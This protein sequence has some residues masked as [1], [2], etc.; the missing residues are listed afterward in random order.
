MK[1]ITFLLLSLC[2]FATDSFGQAM[3]NSD[4]SVDVPVL[5]TATPGVGAGWY[6]DS[7]STIAGGFGVLNFSNSSNSFIRQDVNFATAGIYKLQFDVVLGTGV[8]M[9]KHMYNTIR[10]VAGSGVINEIFVLGSGSEGTSVPDNTNTEET[11]GKNMQVKFQNI[12]AGSATYF[13]T[14]TI[15]TPSDKSIYFSINKQSGAA[16]G[17]GSLK[18]SNVTITLES[19]L[20]VD[21]VEDL[22][23]SFAPNPANSH[24]NVAADSKISQVSLSNA[25]GQVVTTK[26]LGTKTGTINVATLPKGV[27]ILRAVI[28]NAVATRKIMIN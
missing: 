27:Y 5:P 21:T 10:E 4:F 3:T 20:S 23:F 13:A 24:I 9:D 15:D 17:V 14:F 18:V 1:K 8:T 12:N 26:V 7:D 6:G 11:T 22:N 19:E 25:V 2:F 16:D 28:G